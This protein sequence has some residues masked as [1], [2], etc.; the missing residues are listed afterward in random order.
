MDEAL[1]KAIKIFCLRGYHATSIPELSKAMGLASGS[2]YK[3]F[4]DKRAV[5]LAALDRQT[6]V[7]GG[8]FRDAINIAS[9]GREKVRQALMF[10]ASI[11]AGADGRHGCLIVSTAVE[12]ASFDDEIA[13]RA[14][15]ALNRRE[16]Q[17]AELIQIGQTD[18]SVSASLDKE[19]AAKFM[20]CLLQGLRVVG[21][22]SPS[23]ASMVAAVTV[24]M[25]VLD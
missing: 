5:F 18:G 17:L 14:I 11:S 22:T 23:E 12:L 13:E 10:Y 4:S 1:D 8:Q 6:Q 9:T 19:G 20:L 15:G 7:R 2:I 25:K 21:K 16:K 24:A 3:A